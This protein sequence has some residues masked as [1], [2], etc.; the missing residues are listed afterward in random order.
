MKTFEGKL[1]ILV[2][3]Q[4]MKHD[5]G[6]DTIEGRIPKRQ[7]PEVGLICINR[8]DTKFTNALCCSE[9][10]RLAQVNKMAMKRADIMKNPKSEVS[11]AAADVEHRI[12]G[13]QVPRGGLSDQVKNEGCINRRL[14][15]SFETAE[16]FHV[17]VE[18]GTYFGG[19]LFIFQWCRHE[20]HIL[21]KAVPSNQG[22]RKY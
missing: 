5:S 21:V 13:M 20:G 18:S 11:G 10:H 15:T 14:L 3:A 12:I 17:L 22:L 7:Y 2:I 1:P 19:S 8:G 4:V 16:S 9:K 6:K